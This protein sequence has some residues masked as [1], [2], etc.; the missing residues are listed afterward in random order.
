M[1]KRLSNKPNSHSIDLG[2]QGEVGQALDETKSELISNGSSYNTKDKDE[3]RGMLHEGGG[4]SPSN[5]LSSSDV[6]AIALLVVLCESR[7]LTYQKRG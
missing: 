4:K 2:N 5:E 7:T 3:A 1:P 6:K